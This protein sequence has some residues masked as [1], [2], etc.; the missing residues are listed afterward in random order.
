MALYKD[1][2][3]SKSAAE[4]I[5]CI[6]E[7]EKQALLKHKPKAVCIKATDLLFKA[8]GLPVPSILHGVREPQAKEQRSRESAFHT[9]E[10][11]FDWYYVYVRDVQEKKFFVKNPC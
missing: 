3:K 4:G 6:K 5:Q 11:F 10:P 9:S 8:A 2:D 1:G 7:A